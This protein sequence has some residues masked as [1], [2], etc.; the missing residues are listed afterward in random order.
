[1]WR[2]AHSDAWDGAATMPKGGNHGGN[3]G[4]GT[5]IKLV[6]LTDTAARELRRRITGDYA[7]RYNKE[8]ANAAVSE[9]LELLAAGRLLPISDDTRAALPF[10]QDAR[11]MCFHEDAQ[12]GLDQLIAA[13]LTMRDQPSG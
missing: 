13:L 4:G 8:Q 1:V 12:R 6:E 11:R 9:V 5:T 7:T 3:H 2:G 10:L